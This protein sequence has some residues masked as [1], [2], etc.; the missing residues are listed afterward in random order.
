MEKKAVFRILNWN[1]GGAKYLELKSKDD[2]E[3]FRNALNEALQKLIRDHAPDVVT[4][5]EV[6]QYT[7]DPQSD[8]RQDVLKKR[9]TG[10]DG[11]HYWPRWLID[12]ER[13]GH[14][15]KWNLVRDLGRW[16]ERAYFAQGN[17]V[18]VNNRSGAATRRIQHFSTWDLPCVGQNHER[19]EADGSV[20][21]QHEA[22]NRYCME[23]VTLHS[24]LYF[25]DRNTEP[26]A[27]LVS[28]VVLWDG[29]ETTTGRRCRLKDP[30]DIF[31]VNVHFTTLLLERE[32][33]PQIDE[34]AA[35][36]RLQQL[37]IVLDG[38]VSRYNQWRREGYPIRGER[39]QPDAERE[40]HE[41]HSPIWI[42]AG[43]FNFTPESVEYQT[44]V[45]RGFIDMMPLKVRQIPVHVPTKS[46][47]IGKGATITV[48]YVF[49]G[50]RFE[51]IDPIYVEHNRGQSTV[52]ENVT[53]SDHLPMLADVP[54]V[55]EDPIPDD[56]RKARTRART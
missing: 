21:G 24:G 29:F 3:D 56:V 9:R 38:M 17:A 44:M 16:D 35:R 26:R 40:T 28:H 46:Q 25:G 41:R 32:G 11:Y 12:T 49:G 8:R 48:D 19:W 6:V 1:I 7:A 27:A 42:I 54:I 52:I 13:H 31:V 5:Q 36:T 4:L 43:D 23:E 34:E 20:S 39:V 33:V 30:I 45:R 37:Q 22:P 14:Q 47:G 50:P 55:V 15:G 53:V 10:Y 2:R 18:L 51:A